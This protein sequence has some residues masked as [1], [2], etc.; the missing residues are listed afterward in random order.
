MN[1]AHLADRPAPQ[2]W[3][4]P[5]RYYHR[6]DRDLD[7]EVKTYSNTYLHALNKLLS[8]CLPRCGRWLTGSL[9]FRGLDNKSIQKPT[10]KPSNP[11]SPHNERRCN[12]SYYFRIIHRRRTP[13][14][15]TLPS[16]RLLLPLLLL[17]VLAGGHPDPGTNV[18]PTNRRSKR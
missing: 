15:C 7:S 2:W 9:S 5:R 4:H 11:P 14:V 6:P 16:R 18:S 3:T 10:N 1:N 17:L 13:S 8:R 12:Y